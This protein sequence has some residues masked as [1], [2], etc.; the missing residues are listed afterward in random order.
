M[1]VCAGL[2]ESCSIDLCKKELLCH[3][4]LHSRPMKTPVDEAISLEIFDIFSI[5][6][7]ASQQAIKQAN[8]YIP[9]HQQKN[10]TTFP[11]T[12]ALA[13]RCMCGGAVNQRQ[14]VWLVGMRRSSSFTYPLS[15]ERASCAP[16]CFHRVRWV[17][18]TGRG[19]STSREGS[20][21]P[22]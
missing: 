10:A 9:D 21:S 3:S 8:L 1:W 4:P 7:S 18:C 5:S 16:T 2:D 13:Y 22:R 19:A 14:Q 17:L 6:P 15:T 11:L 12:A 20:R